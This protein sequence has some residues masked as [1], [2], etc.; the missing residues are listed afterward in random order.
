M[1]DGEFVIGGEPDVDGASLS[2]AVY[3]RDRY[4]TILASVRKGT[5][6]T[7]VR[8]RLGRW[9]ARL[10]WHLAQPDPFGGGPASRI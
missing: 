2:Q 8:N 10:D 1:A 4:R 7:P 6:G 5:F 9:Q 3:W